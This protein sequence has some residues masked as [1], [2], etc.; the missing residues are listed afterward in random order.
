MYKDNNTENKILTNG[1]KPLKIDTR[2][3]RDACALHIGVAIKSKSHGLLTQKIDMVISFKICYEFVLIVGTNGCSNVT[4]WKEICIQ[5]IELCKRSI[6][7]G[8]QVNHQ[9]RI[10]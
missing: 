5:R 7:N 8:Q 6:D 3:I 10:K 1:I 2:Y 4:L 9:S